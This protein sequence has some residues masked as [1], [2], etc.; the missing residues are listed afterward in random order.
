MKYNIELHWQPEPTWKRAKA[1]KKKC[2]TLSKLK[3]KPGEV[4]DNKETKLNEMQD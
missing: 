2:S 3:H 4:K 1:A